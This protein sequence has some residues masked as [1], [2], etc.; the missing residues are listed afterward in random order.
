MNVRGNPARIIERT[1]PNESN[2]I[3]DGAL[4]GQVVTPDGDLALRASGDPLVLATGGRH[5]DRYDIAL[6][7][8]YPVRLDQGV[9]GKG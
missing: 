5:G 7:N 8:L 6:E 4:H 9:D 3:T 1:D 2:Q